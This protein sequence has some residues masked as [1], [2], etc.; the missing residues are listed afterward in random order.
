MNNPV[1]EATAFVVKHAQYVHIQQ[2]RVEDVVRKSLA[3][4]KA[5]PIWGAPFH[6]ISEDKERQ[7]AW[8]FLVDTM[9]F[10]F[11]TDGERRFRCRQFAAT[12]KRL[13]ETSITEDPLLFFRNISYEN[14]CNLFD[15]NGVL[16]CK[17][18]RWKYAQTVS[19][20]FLD[21]YNGS[22]QQFL[23]QTDY[24]ASKLVDAIVTRIPVFQDEA[25]YHKKHVPFHKR[26]QLL[27]SDM[28]GA[29]VPIIDM[30]YLT[31]FAD[32]RIPQILYSLGI[33]SYVPELEKRIRSHEH[34]APGSAEEV[35]IRA[36]TVQAVDL[37][38]HSLGNTFLPFQTDWLLWNESQT[39][40]MSIPHHRTVTTAY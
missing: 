23:E 37:I 22:I 29:N 20:F 4:H 32:Y 27:V 40:T 2:K 38:T 16:Q 8:L 19:S 35:E 18:E 12:M 3:H 33:L 9:N 14:F 15:D 21:N 31:A 30:D 24:S 34:I 36:A 6:Y 13:F 1:R 28:W 39:I 26:A 11:W 17:H 10:C 7:L 5:P 25:I